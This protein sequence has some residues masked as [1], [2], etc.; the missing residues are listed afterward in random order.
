MYCDTPL[1]S[2]IASVVGG[3]IGGAAGITLGF[4]IVGVA[5]LAGTLAGLGD[6][7]VHVVRKDE[8]FREAV[9][10]VRE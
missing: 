8:Q 9:G 3:L 4:G 5:V 6:L 7:G 1:Q 10:Q 2:L